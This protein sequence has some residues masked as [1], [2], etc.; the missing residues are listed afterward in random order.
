SGRWETTYA[1][2]MLMASLLSRGSERTGLG[3]APGGRV[4]A[5]HPALANA[6]FPHNLTANPLLRRADAPGVAARCRPR[7]APA[8][9]NGPSARPQGGPGRVSAT[10]GSARW[11]AVQ[12]VGK[13]RDAMP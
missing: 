8:T 7:Q 1:A 9:R 6:R 3:A 10:S 4:L 5:S 11:R 2:T 13:R 12:P